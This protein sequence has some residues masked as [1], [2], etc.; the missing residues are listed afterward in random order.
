MLRPSRTPT[1]PEHRAHIH[2]P[3]RYT[4]HRRTS[5]AP[6]RRIP[7]WV[8]WVVGLAL[9]V[10]VY[11]V[12]TWEVHVEI[13]FYRRSWVKQ[14]V[15]RIEPLSGCFSP[16][17]IRAD[18]G[19]YNV[20]R[21]IYGP[22]HNELHA[23]LQMRLGMDCYDYAGTIQP[24][25]DVDGKRAPLPRD[26]RTNFHTYWRADLEP[27]GDRQ[28]WML[29]SFFATQDLATSTLILWSNGD[30][31]E[32]LR[33]ALY[34]QAYPDAFELRIAN[35]PVMSKGT[36]LEN[37]PRLKT[38]DTKAWVDGDLV[39]LLV[40]WRFGG[41]WVDMDSLLTRDLSPLL[42]HEFVTQ[43]DCYGMS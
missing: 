33:L 36:A 24:P 26:Q 34:L 42:E 7:F 37:S 22:K 11:Y 2:A 16:E 27:F 15:E 9:L 17:R 41:V 3:D 10:L 40:L 23:G 4:S 12:W 20:S 32:N 31:S 30:L 19:L 25:K 5:W 43:W 18:G 1:L 6:W 35:I 21:A 8:K 14:E 28:E 13:Q 39:R 38:S 29:K